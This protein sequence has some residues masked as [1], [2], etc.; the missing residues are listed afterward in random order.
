MLD[1]PTTTLGR[2]GL[3]VTRLGIG[4]AYCQTPEGYIKALDTGV[5]YVDTAPAYH[6]G[7]DEGYVGQA[8]V[9]RR[10]NLIVATKTGKRDA[11]GA[12]KELPDR[13]RF[14]SHL[15]LCGKTS[16]YHP[17]IG[18]VYLHQEFRQMDQSNQAHFF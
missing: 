16:L 17:Q 12:R 10:H 8:I 7:K 6:E 4:G 11:D 18:S 14:E 5:T 3:N 1:L 2:T 9:G 13:I 15:L